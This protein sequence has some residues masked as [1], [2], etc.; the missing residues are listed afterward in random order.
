MDS[1]V[2]I[3]SIVCAA[4]AVG[5]GPIALIPCGIA[6]LGGLVGSVHC[7]N[8]HNAALN[9]AN[10]QHA[11]DIQACKDKFNACKA[12]IDAG[13]SGTSPPPSHAER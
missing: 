6:A 4:M 12:S 2:D 13:G 11:R 1:L 5:T 3:G 8:V 10:R 9:A 7:A